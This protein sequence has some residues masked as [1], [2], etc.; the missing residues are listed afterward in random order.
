MRSYPKIFAIHE[1]HRYRPW[2]RP[3]DLEF[4]PERFGMPRFLHIRQL[5]V[6]EPAQAYKNEFRSGSSSNTEVIWWT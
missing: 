4:E 6:T 1:N 2:L 3:L 5:D